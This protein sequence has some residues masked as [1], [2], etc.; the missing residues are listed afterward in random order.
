MA[1][2]KPG[3]TPAKETI[4]RGYCATTS[5]CYKEVATSFINILRTLSPDGS[6]SLYVDDPALDTEA[7]LI[8]SAL[9]LITPGWVATFASPPAA[10]SFSMIAAGAA[11]SEAAP[12]TPTINI[13]LKRDS[14]TL[15]ERKS[16]KLHTFSSF[17]E[18]LHASKKSLAANIKDKAAA[19]AAA[20]AVARHLK[21]N[22]KISSGR[23]LSVVAMATSSQRRSKHDMERVMRWNVSEAMGIAWME[24][25]A[26]NM[27]LSEVNGHARFDFIAQH[28]RCTGF[29][30]IDY[31]E[32]FTRMHR[33]LRRDFKGS[34]YS[35]IFTVSEDL[36]NLE[37]DIQ[38][39]V[40][41]LEALS[42]SL[43][44]EDDDQDAFVNVVFNIDE[45]WLHEDIQTRPSAITE[46][47]WTFHIT[48]FRILLLINKD[49]MIKILVECYGSVDIVD[50]VLILVVVVDV[51]CY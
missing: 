46:Q 36:L 9:A 30:K 17:Q 38:N 31:M 5:G 47:Q 4:S 49:G 51:V 7:T 10:M 44:N 29:W 15:L 33:C 19:R 37:R 41:A 13:N 48:K 43:V 1:S 40:L 14:S 11:E 42:S 18:S 24:S 25:F 23:G 26:R 6:N 20:L 12:P 16:N 45:M 28:H 34:D 2:C 50:V 21:R 32:T 3:K 35:G 27:Q 39:S 22:N 8:E